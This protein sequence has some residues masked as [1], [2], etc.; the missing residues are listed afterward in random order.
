MSPSVPSS[1]SGRGERENETPSPQ[2]RSPYNESFVSDANSPHQR[3]PR[4]PPRGARPQIYFDRMANISRDPGYI[5]ASPKDSDDFGHLTPWGRSRTHREM[6]GFGRGLYLLT[7]QSNMLELLRRW[8]DAL[9]RRI[10]ARRKKSHPNT[11]NP[12]I[13]AAEGL[14]SQEAYG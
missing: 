9:L 5:S 8:V 3:T 4:Y 14:P 7:A 13:S 1:P 2:V 6:V 10:V 11:S 12:D